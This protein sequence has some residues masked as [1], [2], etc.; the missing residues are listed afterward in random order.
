M[1]TSLAPVIL[2]LFDN[3]GDVLAGGFIATYEAGT[4]TPLGTFQDLDG[5]VDNTNP[6]ELDSAGRAV[7]R[8]TDGVAYKFIIT[9]SDDVVIE[10]I[11]DIVVGVSAEA[12]SETLIVNMTFE[13]TPGAQGFMG[14]FIFDRSVTFPI[15]FEGAQASCQ[16]NP[17]SDF[18]ISI[19]K[20]DIEV[21]IATIDPTGT[22]TF[23][24][25]SGVTVPFVTG[26]K[27]TFIGPDVAGTIADVLMTIPGDVV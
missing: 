14:G 9:D 4:M 1:T 6:V 22:A 13:G 26:G 25:T 16:T 24:T 3:Y 27:L 11:D 19:Q 21:G 8:L 2:Q 12:S 10:T 15:D 20:N 23:E 5:D 18:I 7:I 17:A